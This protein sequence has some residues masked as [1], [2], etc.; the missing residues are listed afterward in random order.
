MYRKSMFGE[1]F[2]EGVDL[3]GRTKAVRETIRR[4]NAQREQKAKKKLLLTKRINKLR[5]HEGVT[6]ESQT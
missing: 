6:N 3:D 5:S 1:A 4:I 2:S